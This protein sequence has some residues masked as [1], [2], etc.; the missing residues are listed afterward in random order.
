MGG[1]LE[2][3]LHP[4]LAWGAALASVPLLIHLLN[5]QRHQPLEWAAMRFVM[6]AWRRTRRRS[7]LENLLL[8]LLRMAAVA[9]LAFALARPFTSRSSPL[10]GLTETRRDLVLVLDGSASTGF[11]ES[12]KSVHEAIL[13]RAR[14]ILGGLDGTRGDRVRVLFAARAPRVLSTRAPEDALA[15]LS[16]VSAPLDEPVDLAAALAQVA[17]WAEE[18]SA[19]A[20]SS[21]LEV[22]M[23]TDM[24]RR[25]FVSPTPA[26]A[27][28]SASDPMATPPLHAALDRLHALAVEVVVE[29]LGAASLEPANLGILSLAPLT[30]VLG[31][32]LPVDVGVEIANHGSQ[33]RSAVRVVLEVDGERLPSRSIDVPGRGRTTADFSVTF[34]DDGDHALVARLEGDR[35]GVDDARAAVVRVPRAVRVLLVN[36]DPRSRLDQDEIGYLRAVLE[37][38]DDGSAGGGFSPFE[39]TST[40]FASFGG[41]DLDLAAV[42]VVLLANPGAL[43]PS[44]VEALEARVAAGGALLVTLGDR[45]AEA[46]ALEAL[47]ARLLR[48]DGTGLAPARLLR[49]I[50]VRSRREEAFHV[51]SFVE[52]HPALSFFADERWKPFLVEAPFYAFVA[53]EPAPESSVLAHFDDEAGSPLL[54]ERAYDRGRVLVWTSSI[55]ADWNR[56]PESP[57]TLVPLVHELLRYAASG[58]GTSMEVPVGGTLSP[59]VER[60]PREVTLVRPDGSRRDLD[61]EPEA[62]AKDLWRLPALGPLDT[63]GL[64]RVELAGAHSLP[65][66]VLFEADEGDLARLPAKELEALHPCLRLHEEAQGTSSSDDEERSL[67]GEMWRP[68]ALAALIALVLETV[69]AAWIG[70]GRRRIA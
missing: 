23:L 27:G 46:G 59:E 8:L 12:V 11:R 58:L 3:F 52:D 48:P 29:D 36:G 34:A 65:I 7:R 41:S 39:V 54:I 5:R 35:L 4:A 37:P 50:E 56:L 43:P 13:E 30:S 63:A 40:N 60:F 66:A 57:G 55:D 14:E 2:G 1:L 21:T 17:T 9:L 20:G 45:A 53:A 19:G 44:V 70:R 67:G 26:S 22:R 38:A 68:L 6:A 25:A 10:A 61:G 15:A 49:T 31:A 33:G 62:L 32:R 64:W 24:Q 42:D 69:W 47:N 28:S 51:A 18:D 16:T